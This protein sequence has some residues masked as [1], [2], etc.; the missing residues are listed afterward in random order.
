L[1][2]PSER[3][4]RSLWKRN[5][6][7]SNPRWAILFSAACLC[8][9]FEQLS[10]EGK[11][12]LKADEEAVTEEAVKSDSR[13]IS[14]R[15][16]RRNEL[17]HA[18]LAGKGGLL[19]DF[20]EIKKEEK[21][22]KNTPNSAAT[23]PKT[24]E[25]P[26]AAWN[27]LDCRSWLLDASRRI[28][29][30]WVEERNKASNVAAQ[31]K[32]PSGSLEELEG[33]LVEHSIALCEYLESEMQTRNTKAP[34]SAA[35]AK[36]IHTPRVQDM[37]KLGIKWQHAHERGSGG[38]G[39]VGGSGTQP[40]GKAPGGDRTAGQLLI[41]LTAKKL[42]SI[43]KDPVAGEAFHKELRSVIGQQQT[44]KRKLMLE[45]ATR[46]RLQQTKRKPWLQARIQ[47]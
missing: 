21:T 5:K 6:L 23:S 20:S 45:E 27:L 34:G 43:L 31:R 14:A 24:A 42:G 13:L 3:R 36:R 1:V 26:A 7:L 9:A 28:A 17:H 10:Q 22:A 12:I 15:A 44:R 47:A 46:Q 32:F 35:S 11:A 40:K 8:E 2:R 30:Q 33:R 39:G 16:A 41:L 18:N 29:Q 19:I 25:K 4:T 37:S 38:K